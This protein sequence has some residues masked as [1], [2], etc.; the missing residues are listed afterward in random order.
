MDIRLYRANGRRGFGSQT[1]ADPP[2]PP[3]QP[4][5]NPWKA[6]SFPFRTYEI[7]NITLSDILN[8]IITSRIL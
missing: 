7:L 3:R 5:E 6:D 4:P 8:Y 1:A 2:P